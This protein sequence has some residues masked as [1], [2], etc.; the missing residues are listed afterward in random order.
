MTASNYFVPGN[1]TI[2][3]ILRGRLYTGIYTTSDH[4]YTSGLVVRFIIP[5]TS[6]MQQ[7][8]NQLAQIYVVN[9]TLLIIVLNSFEF[10]GFI[11]QPLPISNWRF[12]PQVIPV[13]DL[14]PGFEG[15]TFN[16]NNI[17]PEI[18]PPAP[19]PPNP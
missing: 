17:I 4:G 18:Y 11:Q 6:G 12:V 13:G 7:L 19:Y 3:R 16:N 9:P 10:D 5:K 8:N 2:W 1:K 15:S 14:G